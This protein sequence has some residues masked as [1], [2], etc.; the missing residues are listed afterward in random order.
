LVLK[1]RSP[2]QPLAG[3]P[4]DLGR[5]PKGNLTPTSPKWTR[6]QLYFNGRAGGLQANF[7]TDKNF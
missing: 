1:H 2:N 5:I 3:A 6:R 7:Q 4:V